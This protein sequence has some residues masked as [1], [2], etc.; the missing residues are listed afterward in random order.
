MAQA[1]QCDWCKKFMMN[2]HHAKVMPARSLDCNG[3]TIDYIPLDLCA[4]CG[5]KFE[6]FLAE[7]TFDEEV[8]PNDNV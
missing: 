3:I 4:K 7:M 1:Y 8:D 5:Q 2:K 6:E